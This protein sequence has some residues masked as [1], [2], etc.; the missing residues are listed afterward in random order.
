MTVIVFNLIKQ[1]ILKSHMLLS[2]W[3]IP[4]I[5]FG[6]LYSSK[7]ILKLMNVSR[8]CFNKSNIDDKVKDSNEE[9]L[10]A[11][12]KQCDSGLQLP[13]SLLSCLSFNQGESKGKF[14]IDFKITEAAAQGIGKAIEV[15]YTSSILN[16]I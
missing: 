3:L 9:A 2:K 6:I 7:I 16:Q 11:F 10:V 1:V 4:R 14:V 8:H 13:F 5:V 12:I 15:S